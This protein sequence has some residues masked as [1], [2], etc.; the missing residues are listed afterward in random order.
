MCVTNDFCGKNLALEQDGSVFSCDHFVYPEYRLGNLQD[1]RL[2]EL[3]FDP[4]QVRF[5][6]AKRETLPAFCRRCPQLRDCWGECPKNRFTRTTEGDPGLN[7]LCSG[8]KRF[9]AHAAPRIDR[10][11]ADLGVREP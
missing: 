11:V 9:Y 7:D 2:G 10:L 1:R 6:L 4:A 5:G 3:A 8:F